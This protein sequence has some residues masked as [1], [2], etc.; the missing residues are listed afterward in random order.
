MPLHEMMK[1]VTDRID[2]LEETVTLMYDSAKLKTETTAM[3]FQTI[4]LAHN[5]QTVINW[6]LIMWPAVLIALEKWLF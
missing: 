1:P 6:F 4:L 5:R 3:V 2:K